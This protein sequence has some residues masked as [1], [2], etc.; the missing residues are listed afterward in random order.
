MSTS[1]TR[2]WKR[3]YAHISHLEVCLPR[4]S[5]LVPL[6]LICEKAVLIKY[7]KRRKFIQHSGKNIPT[8]EAIRERTT[9]AT[10]GN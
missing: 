5:D 3:F 8:V 7:A 9:G 1:T 10:T 4:R 2:R 6:S